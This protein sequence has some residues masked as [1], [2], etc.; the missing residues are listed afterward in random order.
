MGMFKRQKRLLESI[1]YFWKE[2]VAEILFSNL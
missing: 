2:G 1:G